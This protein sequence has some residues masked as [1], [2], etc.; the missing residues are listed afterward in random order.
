MGMTT[1][2]IGREP[3]PDSPRIVISDQTVSRRHA[4]LCEEADGTFVICDTGS[5]SG[6]FLKTNGGWR[7]IMQANVRLGD[8]IRL[9]GVN[10]TIKELLDGAV[11]RPEEESLLRVERNPETGEIVKRRK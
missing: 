5:T 10:T 8:S 11:I 9:G 4:T 1:Y 3:D 2:I 6:T 7:R